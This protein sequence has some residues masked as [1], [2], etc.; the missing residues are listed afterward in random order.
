RMSLRRVI[1][2]VAITIGALSVHIKQMTAAPAILSARQSGPCITME[3]LK[4]NT[5]GYFAFEGN[6][7]D[8]YSNQQPVRSSGEIS[9]RK[10]KCGEAAW[11]KDEDE[12][13]ITVP[14]S[15]VLETPNEFTI[16]VWI[17]P[18]QY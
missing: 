3:S 1:I 8:K 13:R 2:V 17:Y 16:S 7:D 18:T 12:V 6:A 5:V 4:S 11:F 14:H 15:I 10:G 9:F